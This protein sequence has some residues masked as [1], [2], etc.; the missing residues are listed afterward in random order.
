MFP[1]S[2]YSAKGT[3]WE[4]KPRRHQEAREETARQD[5]RRAIKDMADEEL[6]EG[7]VL[8]ADI[9]HV[10][11]YEAGGKSALASFERACEKEV[12]HE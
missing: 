9:L 6:R 1:A 10:R 2:C 5:F 3:E 8:I 4:I 11:G 12:A 7:L